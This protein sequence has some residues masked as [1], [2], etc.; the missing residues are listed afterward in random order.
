MPGVTPASFAAVKRLFQ[1]ELT[2][3]KD[4]DVEGAGTLRWAGDKIYRWVRNT[5]GSALAVGQPCCFDLTNVDNLVSEVVDVAEADQTL[6]AGFALAAAADDYY[7][8][9]QVHGLCEALCDDDITAGDLLCIGDAA[10]YLIKFADHDSA[11]FTAVTVVE[12]WG[13]KIVAVDAASA[14]GDP[15]LATVF[16]TGLI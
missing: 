2:D 10:N 5:S 14:A 8:W 7:T 4:T 11:D 9:I 16:L 3:T 6:F 12:A 1:T 15:E 13:Y